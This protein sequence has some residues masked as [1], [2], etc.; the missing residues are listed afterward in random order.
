MKIA[1]VNHSFSLA[2]GGLERF[3]VNLATGLVQAGHDVHVFGQRFSDLPSNIQTHPLVVP[4]K[5]AWRRVF[6]FHRAAAREV[7]KES[8]DV[9]YGLVRFYPLH[10]YRMGDGVQRHWLR[11]RYPVTLWR[12]FNCLINPVHLVNLWLERLI[13]REPDC[14]IVTNS[15][16]VK[17]QVE[18]Y[19]GVSNERVE[20]IYNGVDH[21]LFNP[22]RLAPLREGVRNEL[23]LNPDDIAILHVSNNWRRKGLAVLLRAVAAQKSEKH[24]LHVVVVGR[25]RPQYFIKLAQRLGIEPQVHFV[26]ETREV[27]RYYGASD[28]M[29]LPT[30]YD[31][32]SNVCLEAMACALPVITTTQNGA[33]ELIHHGENGFLQ[34]RAKDANELADLLARCHNH[35]RLKEMGSAA[36]ED[37]RPYTR[38]KNMRAMLKVFE[39]ITTQRVLSEREKVS[40]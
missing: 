6:S 34:K 21:G 4:R 33:S 17:K 31:P 10:I 16:L 2:H 24:R 12:W 9:V 25:G 30:M 8:F 36:R 28:L 29:V 7:Q 18:A 15:E 38:E 11:L 3:S 14:R 27:D 40:S 20:V 22:E 19:Y 1:L 37:V 32:F 5:P 23:S 39:E 26:G 13:F 35:R